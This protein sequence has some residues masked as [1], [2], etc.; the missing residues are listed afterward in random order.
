MNTSINYP[1]G[2]EWRKWDLHVHTPY[3]IVNNYEGKS[4]EEK[5]DK[6]IEAIENLP[7]EVKVIGITD[8]YFID[9][10]ILAPILTEHRISINIG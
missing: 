4:E 3:S 2:S 9:G 10:Y 7:D 8:Y 5:W 1:K 6:F